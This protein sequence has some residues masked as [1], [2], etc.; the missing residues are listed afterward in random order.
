MTVSLVVIHAGL[1]SL[2]LPLEEAGL[3]LAV[4]FVVLL[5]VAYDIYRHQW[6]GGE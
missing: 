5:V 1:D 4:G 6:S 2:P 3:A